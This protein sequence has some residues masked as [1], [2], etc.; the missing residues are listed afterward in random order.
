[1]DSSVAEA[2]LRLILSGAILSALGGVREASP[3]PLIASLLHESKGVQ[4]LHI[5]CT[6]AQW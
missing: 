2:R 1:M 5:K 6:P 4:K 3:S